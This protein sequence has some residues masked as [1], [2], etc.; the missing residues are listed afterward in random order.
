M[1]RA[2]PEVVLAAAVVTDHTDRPAVRV[3]HH[4]GVAP[5]EFA[6]SAKIVEGVRSTHAQLLETLSRDGFAPIEAV[7]APFD[8]ALHEAISVIPGEGEQV[9]DQVVR[10]GYMM[11]GR[12]LRPSLVVVGHA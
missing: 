8:P 9:V 3:G 4:D 7:G 12:V 6:G 2:P 11:G 5:C 1:R 10:K